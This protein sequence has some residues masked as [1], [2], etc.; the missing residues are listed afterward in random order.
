[1]ASLLRNAPEDDSSSSSNGGREVMVGVKV[2][3]LSADHDGLVKASP[4][5]VI[6]E[7]PLVIVPAGEEMA[8][9]GKEKAA[10]KILEEENSLDIIES[11]QR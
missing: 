5:K 9:E 10:R 1:M 6:K 2:D 8:K 11:S 7:N 3:R 4:V